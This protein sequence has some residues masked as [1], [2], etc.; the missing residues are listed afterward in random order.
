M[1]S[2]FESLFSQHALSSHAKQLSLLDQCNGS[3]WAVNLKKGTLTLGHRV[4]A[5]G[6]LG[7]FSE[8][9]DSWLWSWANPSME[10]LPESVTAVAKQMREIGEKSDIPVFRDASTARMTQLDCHRLA[11]VAVGVSGAEA[12]YC[13]PHGGGGCFLVIQE[14]LTPDPGRHTFCRINR[15][16]MECLSNF[17][18][19]LSHRETVLTYFTSE[20]LTIETPAPTEVIAVVEDGKIHLVFDEVGRFKKMRGILGGT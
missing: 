3:Q 19:E 20:R 4:F 13:G 9:D 11:M 8:A 6:V 15:V 18:F 12:Y 5:V 2:A 7:T 16:I 17:E 10:N 14:P 1:N